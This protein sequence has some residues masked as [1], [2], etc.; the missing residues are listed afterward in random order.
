MEDINLNIFPN[1]VFIYD[2]SWKVLKVNQSALNILGYVKPTDLIGKDIKSVFI[3]GEH[4]QIESIQQ[5]IEQDTT[6]TPKS[7]LCHLH[8]NEWPVKLLSQFSRYS[9]DNDSKKK[10]Y[11]E[12]AISIRE[13]PDF[14]NRPE[15]SPE[16]YAVLAENIPGLEVFLIDQNLIIH[17]RLG[18][19]SERKGWNNGTGKGNHFFDYFPKDIKEIVSPLLTIAFESTPISQEFSYDEEYFSIRLIPLENKTKTL[20][21]VIVL[22]N[23]TETK[24][25]ENKLKLSKEEAEEAN[26]AKDNFVA[27]MSH[28]IRT[29]LN[30]ITG[31]SEQLK[32][33]RMTKK[34]Q[35]YLQVVTNSSKHLLSL[36]DD[37]LVLSKI[38]LGQIEMEEIPFSVS[39]VIQAVNDMLEIKYKEKK[40]EFH[41]SISG[42]LN[43]YV[44]GDPAKLRQILINLV[45]NAIKF[46]HYGSISLICSVID[47]SPLH[48]K[49]LFEVADTGIGISERELKN[50]FKPFHQVDNAFDRNYTGCG[51]GLTISKDLVEKMGGVLLVES[52]PAVGSTFSFTTVFKTQTNLKSTATKEKDHQVCLKHI[53]VLFVDDDKVNRLLGEIILKKF[54]INTDFASSG[55]EAI[56][57]FHPGR[58][59][60]IFLDINMPDINGMEVT[61]YIRQLESTSNLPTRTHIVAMTAN[62]VS[63]HLKQYL[64]SGMDTVMLK[65]YDEE[66]M[67]RKIVSSLKKESDIKTTHLPEIPLKNGESKFN[68][69]Q[70]MKITRG[71]QE[72]TKLMLNIF[73]ENSESLLNKI[74][75]AYS[76]RDTAQMAEAAHTLAPTMEQL[77]LEK[78]ARL[79]KQLEN[80]YLVLKNNKN[81]STNGTLIKIEHTLVEETI[82]EVKHGV[83]IVKD[84]IKRFKNNIKNK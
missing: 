59:N 83:N 3:D 73:I 34:Q 14:L 35:D 84:S 54:G 23:I 80:K 16:N 40:L 20:R 78:A 4:A 32:N 33:T 22:Q 19:E 82:N 11:I 76:Q 30:A 66:T 60:I 81:H 41:I 9:F 5:Q 72:F 37:I 44:F 24:L 36:I 79:L 63:K 58:Y 10:C 43:E 42:N 15:H 46:T 48:K 67:Y 62:A 57:S 74:I 47:Q 13:L 28:E 12:S 7:N 77:G 8:K 6:S 29:P 69:D 39:D 64:L 38:E 31:F 68:L 52:T 27:K 61:K 53:R 65:P 21:C 51:L 1:P 70:L 25:V 45:S 17:S 18:N 2:S 50:I 56:K 75:L 55:L 26:R 49:I 71:D